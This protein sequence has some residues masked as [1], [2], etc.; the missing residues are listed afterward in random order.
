MERSGDRHIIDVER[1]DT[2]LWQVVYSLRFVY[3]LN[4]SKKGGGG[5]FFFFPLK[6]VKHM[7]LMKAQVEREYTKMFLFWV[8][9]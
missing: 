6:S 5:T 4:D 3:M 7:E 8:S 1:M 9:I 2:D